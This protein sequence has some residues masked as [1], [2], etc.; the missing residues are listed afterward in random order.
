[1]GFEILVPSFL[2]RL[3]LF[4][5]ANDGAKWIE[6]FLSVLFLVVTFYGCGTG[7]DGG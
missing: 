1:M 5:S 4:H 3:H 2:H 6:N 7:A